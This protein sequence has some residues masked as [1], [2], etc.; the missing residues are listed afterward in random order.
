MYELDE[1]I[2]SDVDL[3][4]TSGSDANFTFAFRFSQFP[5]DL[6]ANL[7]IEYKRVSSFCKALC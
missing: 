7:A 1:K 3:I 5:L 4:R 2:S 6:Y